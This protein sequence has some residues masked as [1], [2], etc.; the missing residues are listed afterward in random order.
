MN[1]SDLRLKSKEIRKNLNITDISYKITENI[2]ALDI[3]NNA[4]HVMIFYPLKYEVNLLD[5]MKDNKNFYLPR[6]ENDN[7]IACPYKKGD[8]LTKSQFN[9][10]EPETKATNTSELDIVFVP[11]LSADFNYYRLGYGG[12]FY[13]RFI[14]N[15]IWKTDIKNKRLTKFIIVLPDELIAESLPTEPFDTK[16]DGVITQKKASF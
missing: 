3:Y 7:L 14:S 15:N 4:Q 5:L 11:A 12:G 9:T 2:R 1:K 10:Y 13:D 16:C 8:S 6:V